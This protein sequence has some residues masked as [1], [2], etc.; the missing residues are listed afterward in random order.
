M[1]YMS[2]EN[3]KSLAPEIKAICKKYN[4]KATL[5]MRHMST[6]ILNIKSGEI[7]FLGPYNENLKRDCELRGVEYTPATHIDLLPWW[8]ERAYGPGK[9]VDFTKE[10]WA[11]MHKGNHDNSDVMTDYFDVGW[12]VDISVGQWDKPYILEAK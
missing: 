12:Y 4:V 5:A 7:D 10:V 2:Q 3:K 1:A 8:A 6:L 11:A 9:I